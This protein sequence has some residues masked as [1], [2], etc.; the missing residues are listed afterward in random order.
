MRSWPGKG[1]LHRK[2]IVPG[3]FEELGMERGRVTTRLKL[4][5][6]Y[7]ISFVK[8]LEHYPRGS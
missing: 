3:V 1:E 8:E 4:G 7:Y 2:I 6:G 5:L